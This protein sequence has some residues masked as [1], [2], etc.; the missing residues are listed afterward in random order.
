VSSNSFS[1]SQERSLLVSNLRKKNSNIILSKSYSPPREEEGDSSYYSWI[2]D[3][4]IPP[5]GRPTYSAL[6][7]LTYFQKRNVLFIGDS[8]ARRAYATLY[9]AMT[10][11]DLANIQSKEVEHYLVLDVNRAKITEKCELSDR[12]FYNTTFSSDLE[13]EVKLR[14]SLTIFFLCR[15]LPLPST[16]TEAAEALKIQPIQG[17][18]LGRE[19]LFSPPKKFDFLRVNCVSTLLHLFTP[20]PH[21]NDTSKFSDDNS[22]TKSGTEKLPPFLPYL[23]D[24]DLVIIANGVYVN[25]MNECGKT[26]TEDNKIEAYNPLHE[27]LHAL[28]DASS[29]N[30][31]IAYRT[32]GFYGADTMSEGEGNDVIWNMIN[33]T[34][35]FFNE[36]RASE[37]NTANMTLVDWGSNIKKKSFGEERIEGDILA[38]YGLSA[39]LLFTQQLLHELLVA[40]GG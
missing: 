31:Q 30:L 22:S 4:W 16:A 23:E 37:S 7:F 2:G 10:G 35:I 19:K 24:Y 17:N 20:R 18:K 39:R 25:Q 28:K 36:L 40:E 9:G 33:E 11:D 5:N 34:K 12:A 38:H 1:L 27:L 29:P 6:D 21:N 3:Q 32:P 26:R 15:N 14:E 8:T 13:E